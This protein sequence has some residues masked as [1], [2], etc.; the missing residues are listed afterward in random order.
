MLNKIWDFIEHLAHYIVFTFAKLIGIQIKEEKW[1]GF[2]QF[3]KFGM[4]GVSNTFITIVVNALLVSAGIHYQV[5]YFVGYL[6][7]IINAFYWNNKYVFKEKEGEERSIMV[8]FIKC[9]MSYAG[10]YVCSCVL[11]F[12]FVKILG[13]SSYFA[14]ILILFVTIPLNYVLNKKWAFKAQV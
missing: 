4:V 13:L 1:N 6:A 5:S 14:P 10:G 11:L 12:L 3:I 8:A 9:V 2:M 7:G